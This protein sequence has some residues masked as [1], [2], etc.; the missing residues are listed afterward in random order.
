MSKPI[1]LIIEDDGDLSTIFASALAAAGYDT[2]AIRDGEIAMRRLSSMIPDVVV[3]DLHL[4]QVSG[5]AIM[6][7]IRT[8][9]RLVKTR[10]IVATADPRVAELLQEEADLVLIKPVSFSQ[11]R[12]LAKRLI[13]AQF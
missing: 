9:T 2:E 1:A 6:E 7:E 13:P 3:L 11:L 8:D 5:K 12:D 4:P 10:V